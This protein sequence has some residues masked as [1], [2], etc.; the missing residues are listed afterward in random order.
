MQTNINKG[1]LSAT[2]NYK[3]AEL[4]QF[5]KDGL[6]TIWEV[7]EQYWNK[8]S[9]ILF[10]I[11]GALKNGEYIF[12]DKIYQL[13]RH[14]FARDYE[15]EL[16][17]KTENSAEFSLKFNDETLKVYPFEFELKIKY[18]LSDN[19]LNIIYTIINLSDKKMWYSIGAHPAFKLDGNIESYALK[20]DDDKPLTSYLLDKDLFS[21][22]SKEI[23]LNENKLP[24]NYQLFEQDALVFK[25]Q[26]TSSLILIKD[27]IPQL[28][29][30]FSDF[31]YLGIWTK[32]DAPFICI[33][34]WL[35]IADNANATGNLEEKEGIQSLRPH[36]EYK[37][38][39]SVEVL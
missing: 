14:G 15:F 24:L 27:N 30:S 2:I 13:P 10:P 38:V 19:Q 11:V 37:A 31:P 34:P 35:G 8:T 20:F 4:V 25:N 28:K 9:P 21:G 23:Q 33:E 1:N 36:S 39:W 7:D 3:G 29:V 6:N 5:S 17:E 22:E 26:A 18:E 32:L 16:I 12:E